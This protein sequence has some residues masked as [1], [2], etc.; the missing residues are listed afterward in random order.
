M[1]PTV[2]RTTTA[3]RTAEARPSRGSLVLAK[4]LTGGPDDPLPRPVHDRLQLRRGLHQH[5]QRVSFQ[6]AAQLHGQRHPDR[7]ELHRQRDPANGSHRLLVRDPDLQAS[8]GHQCRILNPGRRR[9][10]RSPVTTNNTLTRDTAGLKLTKSLTGGPIGYAAELR[11]IG[12]NCG[13][14]FTRHGQPI[15]Q[16]RPRRSA[17]SRPGRTTP[18]AN[19]TDQRL[20]PATRSGPRPSARRA[21][22]T[23]VKGLSVEVTTNNTLTANPGSLTVTKTVSG[24]PGYTGSFPVSVSCT[25]EESARTGTIAYPTPGSITFIVCP[26]GSICTVTE[27]ILPAAPGAYS[28]GTISYA[29]NPAT[30]PPGGNATV[31]ITN[32][33]TPLQ[34]SGYLDSPK[35]VTGDL[36]DWTGGTFPFTVT[37]N[38][39][40]TSVNLTVGASGSTVSSRACSVRSP[41]VRRPAPLRREP[42]P[43]P[44]RTPLG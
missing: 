33:L 30:I 7:D 16:V 28:W 12:Y 41:R 26:A 8:V 1:P 35:T 18:W 3:A 5:G 29:D 13:E 10:V 24:Y 27:L 17:A 36:T 38:G 11:P 4:S 32:P 19:W 44:A 14:G 31:G 20:P 40:A 43:P 34:G 15:R 39:Q 6:P 25:G 42:C 23:I 22:V 37:C 2:T 21:T 9:L